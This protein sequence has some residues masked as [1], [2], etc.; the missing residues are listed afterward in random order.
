MIN[1]PEIRHHR[2]EE[3]L[4][5]ADMC[6]PLYEWIERKFQHTLQNDASLDENLMTRTGEEI[7]ECIIQCYKD[8][9]E[10]GG[11]GNPILY[12]GIGLPYSAI[13]SLHKF[14]GWLA[15]DMPDQRLNPLLR[16]A[17][18]RLGKD[19]V[20]LELRAIA[21][22]NLIVTY[23]SAI[24][25]FSWLAIREVLVDR[26]EG[27][28]RSARAHGIEKGLR[29]N[30]T[31]ILEQIE[32][33][34][35]NDLIYDKA[36]VQPTEV[37]LGDQSYDIAVDFS[38]YDKVQQRLLIPVKTRETQGGGHAILYERELRPAVR[39]AKRSDPPA[40]VGLIAIAGNWPAE[41]AKEICD[42]VVYLP[43]DT[44]VSTELG[45]EQLQELRTMLEAIYCG[46]VEPK[47]VAE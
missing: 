30:V 14:F 33:D 23:R 19:I 39:E 11:E 44:G 41:R 8:R 25:S 37:K 27:S 45:A 9:S 18:R 21:Y 38:K 10:L 31:K 6:Y 28:R 15:R 22:A 40:F 26:L 5:I 42:L 46:E 4:I 3:L 20:D 1:I 2:L 29:E 17:A 13:E 32:K 24:K 34:R 47:P 16:Q 36:T 7:A 12:N 35:A 43:E